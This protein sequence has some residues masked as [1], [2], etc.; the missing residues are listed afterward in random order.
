[1]I[2]EDRA[3]GALLGLA[4]GD[5]LGAT[6]EFTTRDSRPAITTLVG[7]GPF[8]L[9]PGQWTDDTS[10]ALCLADSLIA[11]RKLDPHDL[12]N[13]FVSW[14]RRGENSVTGSCFDIG[15]TTASSLRRFEQ[16][17][18]V[19][20]ELDPAQAGNGSLMRL[21][22]VVLFAG[23]SADLA[24]ELAFIQSR[25]THPAREAHDACRYF[26][27]LLHEA[28]SGGL[29]GDVLNDR[30]WDGEPAVAAIAAGGW[31]GKERSEISSSGYVIH[32]LEA[33]LWCVARADSFAEAVLLAANLGDDS[34]T[35]AAVTGQLAGALWGK[36]GI[37]ADWVEVLAWSGEIEDRA[38]KLCLMGSAPDFEEATEQPEFTDEI[39]GALRRT[40]SG[41]KDSE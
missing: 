10:M 28:F 33:A 34:D 21:A 2:D 3:V 17:G 13:R 6:L 37:P 39:I 9:K 18:E 25:T 23:E 27:R 22:P 36:A 5:A 1:M 31:R 7:G 30:A 32:T 40:A 15:N 12:L 20:A 14:W 19:F 38:R 24:E 29:K 8:N 41:R 35:V 4:V 11:C 26:S 16:T